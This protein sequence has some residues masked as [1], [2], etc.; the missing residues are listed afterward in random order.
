MSTFDA[1][2]ASCVCTRPH[3]TAA[4][5]AHTP[6]QDAAG[7]IL[8]GGSGER[9]GYP[10]GK[11]FVNL[12]GLPMIAWSILVFDQAPSISHLVIASAKDKL[13]AVR[14]VLDQLTLHKPCL[15]AEAGVTRQESSFAALSVVPESCTYA[16]VHDAARPL[17]DVSMVEESLR[18]LREKPQLAG[19][20]CAAPSIDTIKVVQDGIIQSTPPRE[21][22]WCAQTPQTFRRQALL[23]A[24]KAARDAGFVGT[25][26]GSLLEALSK[27][28]AVVPTS[29]DNIKVTV[30]EDCA[31]AEYLLRERLAHQA[32]GGSYD[33]D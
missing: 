21:T 24:H 5:S 10:Q 9:F 31:L 1:E 17:V 6:A 29:R 12:L 19:A 26:D 18:I 23:D 30:P 27:P 4:R 33:E 20:L 13:D 14:E 25:D 2:S 7:V 16:A 32:L 11:Q 15:F 8:A 22:L 28:V 3:T